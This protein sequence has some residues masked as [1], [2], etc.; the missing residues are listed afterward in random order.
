[1]PTKQ[2]G[3][4]SS[5]DDRIIGVIAWLIVVPVFFIFF[6]LISMPI[7]LAWYILGAV[8]VGLFWLL[9]I[10]AVGL[11]LIIFVLSEGEERQKAKSYA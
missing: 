11:S 7:F 8:L 6:C 10:V 9:V 4:E 1:M 2:E 3:T 5:L